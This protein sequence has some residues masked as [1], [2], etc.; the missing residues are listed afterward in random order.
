LW[1]FSGQARINRK[2]AE[3]KSKPHKNSACK[4]IF[5]IKQKERNN[6]PTTI[7]KVKHNTVK[8]YFS[9]SLTQPDA[10]LSNLETQGLDSS[11]KILP[12]QASKTRIELKLKNYERKPGFV[13]LQ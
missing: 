12:F 7:I 2:L 8:R 11:K 3:T 6:Q 4:K 1:G 5:T 13:V 10:Y 9:S